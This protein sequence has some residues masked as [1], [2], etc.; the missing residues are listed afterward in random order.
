MASTSSDAPPEKKKKEENRIFN[1]E[2]MREFFFILPERSNAKPTC[3]ICSRTLASVKKHD[4]RR[5]Y[6][7]THQTFEQKYPIGSKE[8]V[9]KLALL[10]KSHEYS[11]RIIVKSTTL[12][13]KTT[14]ASLRVSWILNKHKM[15]F[16]SSEVVKECMVETA[17]VL[18]P[19]EVETFRKIPLSNDTN[20]RRTEVMAET[21][22]EK[23]IDAL[24]VTECISIA[25][26]ESTDISDV[27]QLSLFVR[28]LDQD[29]GLF[30]EELLAL[31]P[32]MGSTTGKDIH[33]AII[34]C[35]QT[36]EIPL[37][38]ITCLVTD[39]APAMVG[40]HNG[41][42][43]LLKKDCPRLLTFHCIIHNSVLCSKLKGEFVKP[44]NTIISLVNFLRA[45]SAKQHRDVKTFLK[46][47]E[48]AYHDVPLHT[49]V[50]WLSKG[51]VLS[52]VWDLRQDLCGFLQQLVNES[53][54]SYLDFLN[55]KE[56]MTVIAFLVDMFEH[57][58]KLNLL[59]QGKYMSLSDVKTEVKAFQLQLDVFRDDLMSEMIHFTQLKKYSPDADVEQFVSF[60]EALSNE[61][62]ERF[63]NFAFID[64]LLVMVKIPFAMEANGQWLEQANLVAPQLSKAKL[65]MQ[66][67]RMKADDELRLL[68][69][70]RGNEST[71]TFWMKLNVARY[72]ELR[73]LGLT[74]S[75]M[76]GTTYICKQSFS[77]MNILK[78]KYRS[79][80]TNAHLEHCLRIC[81]TSYTPN[82]K[83]IALTKKCNF[84]H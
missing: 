7:K 25:T 26:D 3:L 63:S 4:I 49:A 80:L 82:F 72:G 62:K 81:T 59:L 19:N 69:E 50:R 83:Q 75:G 13:E 28:Y 79:S 42:A 76:F 9:E 48:A 73:T 74:V 57:L 40:K 10:V 34:N 66:F 1:D 33:G 16:S 41:A 22:K 18:C 37:E 39:G 29:A 30:R 32:M 47:H 35:L 11:T 45:K 84:S 77:H 55:D 68:F 51:K 46:E 27:A 24:K 71:A 23:L 15:A 38:K 43:T 5:H 61:F 2:W 14:E 31:I 44:M 21:V 56:E 54:Q 58:N 12:Q 67:V 64:N 52:R 60:I 8:R 6:T 78:T 36:N 20:T 53:S 70:Q 65:Q 17:R